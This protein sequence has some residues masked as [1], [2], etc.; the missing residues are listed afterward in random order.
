ML[1]KGGMSEIGLKRLFLTFSG[2]AIVILLILSAYSNTLNSPAVLDDTHSFI[3]EPLIQNF[4]GSC[5]S[6]LALTHSKFGWKR[7]IPMLTI[8]YDSLR[9]Q[10]HLASFHL[11]NILIHILTTLAV[12][13]WARLLFR[14]SSEYLNLT[15]D[16][17]A[18]ELL[19]SLTVASI[20]SLVPVQTNVVTYIVQRMA[21]LSA[22]FYIVSFTSY[23]SGRM[24]WVAK[25]R[26]RAVVFWLLSLLSCFAA[27]MSKENAVTLPIMILVG[28]ELFFRNQFNSW[29][30]KH[31]KI[32]IV[33]V[34]VVVVVIVFVASYK[35]I[36]SILAGYDGRHFTLGERL[37]T[38]LR[39]V[40]SYIHLL[41]FPDPSILCLDSY[42]SIST[43]L[44]SPISTLF[45]L[46]LLSLLLVLSWCW[47]YRFPLLS[48]GVIWFFCNLLIESSFI[49]LELKFE[50]RLYLP[51]C[52]FYIFLVC[53]I[54]LVFQYVFKS[55][56]NEISRLGFVLLVII[57]LFLSFMTHVRNRTW[58]NV[59]TIYEDCVSKAPQKA[60]VHANLS[61]AYGRTGQYEKA[62]LEAK[63]AIAI[64]VENYEAY[65][66]AGCNLL[67]A[68][69][70]QG[71]HDEALKWGEKLLLEVP[72]NAKINSKPIFLSNLAMLYARSGEYRKAYDSLSSAIDLLTRSDLPYLPALERDM[73][74]VLD[75]ARLNG[76]EEEL[77]KLGL[78]DREKSSVMMLMAKLFFDFGEYSRARDYASQV[79]GLSDDNQ[80]AQQFVAKLDALEQ[81]NKRQ[82]LYGTLKQN[83][84]EDF[85]ES[86][87]NFN[88]AV[89]Y[90]IEKFNLPLDW[91]ASI[92]LQR[93]KQLNQK[94]PDPYLLNSWRYYSAQKYGMAKSELRKGMLFD[95]NYA[96]LWVNLGMY[97]LAAQQPREA[98]L[99]LK[100]AMEL[101][102]SYPQKQKVA[103]MVVAAK[104]MISSMCVKGS[105]KL[106][107]RSK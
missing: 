35:L 73:L 82:L 107:G 41:I 6:V 25:Y 75:N 97:Q 18:L 64:G 51:S 38:E 44:V 1:L 39:V 19:L 14:L 46:L 65:W 7:F 36:P 102:P 45:S 2:L 84:L 57:G 71:L 21:G 47:R 58:V 27:F 85:W 31:K 33:V 87:F 94:L 50:H 3:D 103:A 104:K 78:Q 79:V 32:V 59:V 91:L 11:T 49:P 22:L 70:K 100:R 4:D 13:F 28:E 9:G 68:Y 12:F 93:A 17:W 67:S 63:T 37:L 8:A 54:F 86:P 29:L 89:A 62:I 23:F 43:S 81:A 10:G 48:L 5:K 52:G 72:P 20:W 16:D 96:Q 56:G 105:T 66:V 55:A 26:K 61:K 90:I 88:M 34:V 74:A 101:Y 60:R 77:K 69:S 80:P 106:F 98:I 76:D 92:C 53:G 24:Q 15:D 83:Y 30:V 99:S 95:E 42:V 40:V